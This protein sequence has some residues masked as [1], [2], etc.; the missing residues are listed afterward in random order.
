VAASA[1]ARRGNVSLEFELGNT[2]SHCKLRVEQGKPIL[3]AGLPQTI[4][5]FA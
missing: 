2:R 5:G 3:A 4:R 1:S